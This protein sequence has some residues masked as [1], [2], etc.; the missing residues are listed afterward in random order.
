MIVFAAIAPHPPMSIPG[1]GHA[2]D[3]AMLHKT[4]E[5]YETLRQDIE[6]AN[7]DLII[8]ISPHGHM[9]PYSFVVNSAIDLVGSFSQFSLDKTLSF[10]NDIDMADKIAYTAESNE[11]ATQL[12]ADFLDHGSLVPLFHLT[13]NIHP[14][15]VHLSFSLMDLERHY[16]YGQIIHKLIGI[17]EKRRVAI[18][19][20]GDL[21][22]KLSSGSPAG[23]SPNA[24]EF[25]RGFMRLL[26]RKEVSSIMAM[27]QDI[28]DEAAECGVRSI[29]IML[30]ILSDKKY[31]FEML[32]YEH[33]FGIGYLTARLV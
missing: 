29:M 28:M 26:A 7:P 11:I 27:E 33:P 6:R 24:A 12:H 9:E 15:V 14:K 30:G 5:A 18:I 32:S 22:H 25:D 20:S 21:S 17:D 10:K 19:A 31:E 2:Q 8:V 23:F 13:K 16:R 4:L 1:I 3:F